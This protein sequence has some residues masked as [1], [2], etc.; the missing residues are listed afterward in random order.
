[1]KVE[2]DSDE[3]AKKAAAAAQRRSKIMQQM[4]AQQNTFMK[5]NSKLFDETP[6]GLREHKASI[7]EWEMEVETSFPGKEKVFIFWLWQLFI[8]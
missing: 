2:K 8:N 7:S 3:K 4:A 6:S 1:M 5:E